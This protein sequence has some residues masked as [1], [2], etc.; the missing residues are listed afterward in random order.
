MFPI[1]RDPPEGGTPIREVVMY[2]MV[3]FLQDSKCEHLRTVA[4]M[5]AEKNRLDALRF[6]RNQLESKSLRQANDCL[7]ALQD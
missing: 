1:S 3:E 7:K 4:K 2:T 6:V 5:L